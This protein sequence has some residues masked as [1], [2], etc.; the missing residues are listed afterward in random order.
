VSNLSALILSCGPSCYSAPD[1]PARHL[2]R[3]SAKRFGASYEP[4]ERLLRARCGAL[5]RPLPG[6]SPRGN[7][8]TSAAARHPRAPPPRQL[9]P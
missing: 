9:R 6:G 1:H 4:P 2:R 3:S 7:W 8:L 5:E